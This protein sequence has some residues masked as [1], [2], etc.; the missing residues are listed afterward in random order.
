V[1]AEVELCYQTYGDPEAEPLLL[2]MGLG[3]PMTWWNPLLCERLARNG[4]YVIRFDNRDTGRSSRGTGRVTGRCWCGLSSAAGEGAVLDRRPG[5]R[6]FG[7]LDH[8]G[9]ESAHITG[10]R[11]AG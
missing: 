10:V 4:F 7:L 6:R 3:G 11:W 2:I 9:L 8:L 1:S 5:R